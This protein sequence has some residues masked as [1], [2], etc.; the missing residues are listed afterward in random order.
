VWTQENYD[1]SKWKQAKTPFGFGSNGGLPITTDL[2]VN[3][4]SFKN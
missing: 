3:N 2:K 1:D 4:N